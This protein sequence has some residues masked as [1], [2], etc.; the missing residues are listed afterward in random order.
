MCI[1]CKIISGE[2]PS[3]P[4]YQ[5]EH[6]LVIKDIAPAAPVHVLILPKKHIDN[7]SQIDAELAAA[8]F[9]KI[10]DIAKLLGL[11]ENGY[12]LVVNTGKDG[13]QTVNHLH[14]HLL[15][16]RELAWPAG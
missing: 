1:F 14:I 9:P 7:I 13:G 6:L 2:I 12:R 10:K 11:E 15:G 16:G 8:V 4:V 5:D 3:E